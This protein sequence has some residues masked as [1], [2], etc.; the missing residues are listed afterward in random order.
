MKRKRKRPIAITIGTDDDDRILARADNEAVQIGAIQPLDFVRLPV[1]TTLGRGGTDRGAVLGRIVALQD[2]HDFSREAE[3]VKTARECLVGRTSPDGKTWEMIYKRL[4]IEPLG[5]V[6]EDGQLSEYTGGIGYFQ[7]VFRAGSRDVEMLYP[8]IPGIAI[9]KVASGYKTS[10]VAFKLGVHDTLTRHM[11]VFGKTGTGKTN[12]LKELV[13]ANLQLE[14]PIAMLLFGH[15][16]LA[17]DNPNDQG[18]RGLLSLD[19]DR[20]VPVGLGAPLKLSTEELMLEDIF[21]QFDCSI[22]QKDLWRHVHALDPREYIKILATYDTTED[23]LGLKRQTVKNKTTKQTETAGIAGIRT[24]DAVCRQARILHRNVDAAAPKVI[25]E[26]LGHLKR[27]RVVLVNTS[28]M[29]DYYQGMFV[30]L[31][32]KRLQRAGKRAMHKGIPQRFFV[33]IDEAQY[34]LQ[35]AGEEIA[36][37]CRECR[38]F[39]ITLCL[40]TQSPKAIP[41]SVYGQI[42]STIAFHLN[43]SDIKALLD[44]APMLAECKGMI[45]RPPLRT[46]LGL[47]IV[48]A[49]GYP[50]PAVIRIP[51]FERRLNG[52]GDDSK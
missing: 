45:V 50:Y 39:G 31:L 40:L 35:V 26:I 12:F 48:Q 16:D 25:S 51:R 5:C 34:F 8:D 21:H 4:V 44:A 3:I 29:S 11:A 32:L 14:D 49:V 23:P 13:A 46:T 37:F 41:E 9:G 19:D 10:G 36:D 27:R 17:C 30:K 18:T 20:I 22:A 2:A 38:K 6:L 24:I 47:G 43:R 28:T 15:P 1:R 7:P 42:Y 52:E 33:V